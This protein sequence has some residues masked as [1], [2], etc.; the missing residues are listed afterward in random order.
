[1]AGARIP[2]PTCSTTAEPIDS[3]TLCRQR[4]CAP[5]GI[6]D[7][8]S[9]YADLESALNVLKTESVNFGYR[10][11]NDGKVRQ[12]YIRNT[13]QVANMIR[14]EVQAGRLTP[15]EGALEANKLR[16]GILDAARIKSSDIGRAKAEALKEAGKT[17]QDLEEHYARK[18]FK[19][20]FSALSIEERNRVWMEIVE[21]SGR[22]RPAMNM[23]AARLAKVGRGLVFASIGFAVYNIST[24]EDKPRQ[25]AKEGTTAGAG[26]LGGMAG[27]AAAGLACGPGAPVCVTVG[28]FVGGALAAFGA[29]VAFDWLW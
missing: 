9:G 1:M 15:G 20:T 11:I 29:D 28:V 16:N 3:G 22:P 8:Q 18:F 14:Q 12:A 26:V 7:H 5:G 13:E 21:A 27:G 24:A 17:L 10:F 6:D 25:I 19:K 4:S 23:K 2:G